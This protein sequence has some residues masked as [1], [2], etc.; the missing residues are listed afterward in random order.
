MMGVFIRNRRE[1]CTTEPLP[2]NA[3]IPCCR[4]GE[5]VVLKDMSQETA[6]SLGAGIPVNCKKCSKILLTR[7]REEW[8]PEKDAALARLGGE[9]S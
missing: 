5:T 7:P 4:C 9:E 2:L 1:I 6:L 8:P 3:T